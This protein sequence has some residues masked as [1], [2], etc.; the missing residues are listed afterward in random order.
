[1][2][3]SE[4][5]QL[6]SSC[7]NNIFVDNEVPQR[8]SVVRCMMP[9]LM[10]GLLLLPLAGHSPELSHGYFGNRTMLAEEKGFG[11]HAVEIAECIFDVNLASSS[12]A[13][14][15][16][17]ITHAS[18][19]CQ[20]EQNENGAEPPE[21]CPMATTEI[22]SIFAAIAS[23]I[24]SGI[25][26]CP[27]LKTSERAMCSARISKLLASLGEVGIAGKLISEA[28]TEN[29]PEPHLYHRRLM[30]I[31]NEDLPTPEPA[32]EAETPTTPT[33]PTTPITPTTPTTPT[34]PAVEIPEVVVA[35]DSEEVHEIEHET[36]EDRTA[37]GI[38]ECSIKAASAVFYLGKAGSD[39]VHAAHHCPR[40]EEGH[41]GGS[42]L[43]CSVAV[44]NSIG[45]L[46]TVA[47]TLA[48]VAMDCAQSVNIKTRCAVDV[49][50]LITALVEVAASATGIHVECE[51]EPHEAGEHSGESEHRRLRN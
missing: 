29:S 20:K 26:E 50:K 18:H 35:E 27:V 5:E 1:M 17:T 6:I 41:E 22:F 46:G 31:P 40:G 32:A 9:L 24:S 33:T 21:E 47:N 14:A 30:D 15:G 4:E 39:I 37:L 38:A 2:E 16:A 11:E 10:L 44:Q 19:H 28:C 13:Y 48:T 3:H 25:S 23:F 12:L 43:A 49:T 36:K 34:V 8:R 7:D 42:D 51:A 45:A